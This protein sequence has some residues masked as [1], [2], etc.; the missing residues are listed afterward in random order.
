MEKNLSN[1]FLKLPQTHRWEDTRLEGPT[2]Q[3]PR[4]LLLRQVQRV[5]RRPFPRRRVVDQRWTSVPH[6]DGC[7]HRDDGPAHRVVKTWNG[8]FTETWYRG[9][10]IHRDAGAAQKSREYFSPGM[11]KRTV[12][13][14]RVY[15][16]RGLKHR[17]TGPAVEVFDKTYHSGDLG[18]PPTELVIAEWWNDGVQKAPMKTSHEWLYC[19]Y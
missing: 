19:G 13:T 14:T 1:G 15:F 3:L 16:N 17:E 4:Y 5:R 12:R 9:G 18:E 11:G 6:E 10:V 8:S 2:V 7:L